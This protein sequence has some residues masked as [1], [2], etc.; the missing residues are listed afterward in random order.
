MNEVQKRELDVL[1]EIIKICQKHDLRYFAIGGTC[2]GAVR[3]NG[4]IPWDDD[5]DIAMP[6]KDYEL[7]R[8][9]YYKELPNAFRKLDCDNS[10]QHAFE[11]TKIHDSR[12]TYVEKY[13][14]GSPERYTG[15]FVDVMPVD[16]L[17]NDEKE[18]AKIIKKI[19]KLVYLN[20]RNRPAPIAVYSILG[21][22]KSII[23]MFFVGFFKYNYFSD[24]VRQLVEK[25]SFDSSE[26][27]IFTWR[28]DSKDLTDRRLIFKKS[29]FE[30]IIEVA[31]ENT[32]IRIP[33]EYDKYLK[34]D[35]GD[36]MKMPPLVEQQTHHEVYINDMNTSCKY[37][38]ERD[39]KKGKEK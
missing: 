20:T 11:F 28:A 37:Y 7:F 4:F 35:F 16:G 26:M 8:T 27:C 36:Y 29:W 15:A 22:I 12:T 6:R 3:H 38:A 5:I 24:K 17:P 18:R 14:K 25:Y 19:K 30:N 1:K 31:F 10:S 23:K 32:V 33:K 13:A 21:T 9:K 2:I 34:Q 39:R